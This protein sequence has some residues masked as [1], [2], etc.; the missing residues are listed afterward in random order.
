MNIAACWF[1]V[2]PGALMRVS[3][4]FFRDPTSEVVQRG[5]EFIAMRQPIGRRS[6]APIGPSRPETADLAQGGGRSSRDQ[7]LTSGKQR[8]LLGQKIQ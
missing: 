7:P 3:I 2:V 5:I 4:R 6:Q 8:L 1:P